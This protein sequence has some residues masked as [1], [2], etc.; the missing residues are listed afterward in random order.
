MEGNPHRGGLQTLEA[1]RTKLRFV[2]IFE[3]LYIMISKG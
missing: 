2:V 3:V 1:M